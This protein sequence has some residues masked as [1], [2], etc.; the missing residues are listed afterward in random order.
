MDSSRRDPSSVLDSFSSALKKKD[1]ELLRYDYI[2]LLAIAILSRNFA[3]RSQRCECGLDAM[4]NRLT[5]VNDSTFYDIAC[6]AQRLLAV[7]GTKES[8]ITIVLGQCMNVSNGLNAQA[9]DTQNEWRWNSD[10]DVVWNKAVASLRGT[11]K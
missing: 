5:A 10:E 1:K 7:D 9:I 6:V 11:T 3:S 4:K 8:L 2:Y